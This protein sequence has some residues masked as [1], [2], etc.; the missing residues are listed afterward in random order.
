MSTARAGYLGRA[1]G[2]LV[3]GGAAAAIRAFISYAHDSPEHTELVRRL[4]V[5]LRDNGI[6]ARCDLDVNVRQDWPWWMEAELPRA[7]YVLVVA[8]PGYAARATERTDDAGRGVEYEASLLRELLYADRRTW[9]PRILPV[10]LPGGDRRNVPQFLAT[11]GGTV[12]RVSDFT[13]AGA[14]PLLRMLTSQPAEPTTPIGEVP[15]L[16]PRHGP[17]AR[18]APDVGRLTAELVDVLSRLP[19]VRTPGA[20]RHLTEMLRE[21]LGGS[22]DLPDD[23]EPA[24]YLS[25]LVPTLADRP[26]GLTALRD[27]VVH[28]HRGEP[29]AA[30]VR[31]LVER[32]TPGG[33]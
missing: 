25:V 14:E 31:T 1:E 19:V 18:P 21:R 32:L 12:Y 9:F 15:V 29:V 22:L 4:W 5:L 6:D 20:R 7:H 26:G 27:V 16:P 10:V 28:L 33:R 8:S 13:V 3:V 17:S 2:T 24:G 30:D 11:F 23:A